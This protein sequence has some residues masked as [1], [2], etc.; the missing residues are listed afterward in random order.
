MCGGCVWIYVF[1]GGDGIEVD[2]I[3]LCD[4]LNIC[5][6]LWWVS[7]RFDWCFVVDRVRLYYFKYEYV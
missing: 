2:L 5:V 3:D 7:W 4:L 1:C 6:C